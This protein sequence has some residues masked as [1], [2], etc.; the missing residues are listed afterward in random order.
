MMMIFLPISCLRTSFVSH[1]SLQFTSLIFA[2]SSHVMSIVSRCL[3][4]ALHFTAHWQ[5]D[6]VLLHLFHISLP[7]PKLSPFNQFKNLTAL[8][9]RKLKSEI[10]AKQQ[11]V[12]L[13]HRNSMGWRLNHSIPFFISQGRDDW[14]QIAV[15]LMHGSFFCGMRVSVAWKIA[16]ERGPSRNQDSS[17][18]SIDRFQIY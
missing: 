16:P 18:P 1:T 10:Q 9:Q 7:C 8:F 5:I 14:I 13:G 15:W 6:F 3:I 12:V 4:F 17:L 11:I 2:L